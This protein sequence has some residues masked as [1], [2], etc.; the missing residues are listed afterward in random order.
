MIKFIGID[1]NGEKVIGIGLTEENIRRLK[2]GDPILFSCKSLGLNDED[3][4]LVV[5]DSERFRSVE[6]RP[7]ISEN[8]YVLVLND[9][10]I[11]R[12]TDPTRKGL[13]NNS[14]KTYTFILYYGKDESELAEKIKSD[15]GSDLGKD[16]KFK[17]EG[18]PP[19]ANLANDVFFGNN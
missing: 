11:G 4:I 15:L 8:V 17:T 3:H 5:Y 2:Q 18:Y 9:E 13:Y 14:H 10:A 12:L 16:T 6:N 7:S 1:A 19:Y